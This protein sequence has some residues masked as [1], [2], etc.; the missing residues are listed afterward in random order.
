MI[1]KNIYIYFQTHIARSYQT[2]IFYILF[3]KVLSGGKMSTRTL[4]R[5]NELLHI[6]KEP[7]LP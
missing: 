4:Q 3:Y 6:P 5:Y 7:H 1:K 2:I